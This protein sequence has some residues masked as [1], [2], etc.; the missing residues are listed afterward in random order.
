MKRHWE[1]LIKYG[2]GLYLYKG[3]FIESDKSIWEHKY[4]PRWTSGTGNWYIYEGRND[5]TENLPTIEVRKSLKDCQRVIDFMY[6]S[7]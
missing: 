2:R 5:R 6:E 4:N 1:D 7:A 3:Y